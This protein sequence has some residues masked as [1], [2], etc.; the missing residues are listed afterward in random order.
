MSSGLGKTFFKPD[1]ANE[2]HEAAQERLE[3][4]RDHVLDTME[5]FVASMKAEGVNRRY[6]NSVLQEMVTRSLNNATKL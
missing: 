3:D 2:L 6:F 4:Q 5:G 1:Y